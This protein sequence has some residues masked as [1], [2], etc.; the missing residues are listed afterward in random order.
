ML[1]RFAV[2]DGEVEVEAVRAA[3]ITF[4]DGSLI[5]ALDGGRQNLFI[6]PAGMEDESQQ[7][8]KTWK[9]FRADYEAPARGKSMRM[10]SEAGILKALSTVIRYI[11]ACSSHPTEHAEEG[12]RHVK[13]GREISAKGAKAPFVFTR[14]RAS[15]WGIAAERV[16]KREE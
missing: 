5:V 13:K 10:G 4:Q 7:A 9:A 2:S 1:E 6:A 16:A 11:R 15:S 12:I 14:T 3:V 8:V